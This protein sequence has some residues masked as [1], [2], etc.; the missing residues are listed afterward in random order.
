MTVGSD[1]QIWIHR[2]STPYLPTQ[3]AYSLEAYQDQQS[4][5]CELLAPNVRQ[6]PLANFPR[7]F[8]PLHPLHPSVPLSIIHFLNT[9]SHSHRSKQNH[10][11]FYSLSSPLKSCHHICAVLLPHTSTNTYKQA[12]KKERRDSSLCITLREPF[13]AP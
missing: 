9:T 11:F 1:R 10:W 2:T 13:M 5:A 4:E 6:S 3:K 7:F 12:N 8:E